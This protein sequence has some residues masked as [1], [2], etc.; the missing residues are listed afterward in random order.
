MLY[1]SLL[2]KDGVRVISVKEPVPQ[3]DKFAVIY[4]SML[5]AMAEYYSLNLA[6]EVKKSMTRDRK[7]VV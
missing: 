4:E 5:E 1:K 3:D 2:K 6:E 7:S